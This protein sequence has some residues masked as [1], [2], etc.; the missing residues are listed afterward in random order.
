[1]EGHQ[2]ESGSPGPGLEGPLP[3]ARAL[4]AIRKLQ[5]HAD[6]LRAVLNWSPEDQRKLFTRVVRSATWLPVEERLELRLVLPQPEEETA[7]LGTR[8]DYV[9]ARGRASTESTRVDVAFELL[10][11]VPW[12]TPAR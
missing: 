3:A 11:R 6:D 12:V 4:A 8:V 9:R 7:A 1:V 2:G 5:K 10:V